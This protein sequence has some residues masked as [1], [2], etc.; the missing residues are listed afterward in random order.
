MQVGQLEEVVQKVNIFCNMPEIELEY[1][2]NQIHNKILE[3]NW[4]V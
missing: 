2:I 4:T 1:Q 3:R